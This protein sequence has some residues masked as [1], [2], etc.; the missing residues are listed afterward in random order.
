MDLSEMRKG[1]TYAQRGRSVFMRRMRIYGPVFGKR[2]L[3]LAHRRE[4]VEQAMGTFRKLWP[5]V[6]VG[7]Y[8]GSIKEKDAFVVCGS[9]QSVSQ[10]LEDFDPNEF[11]Y[12][13][14]DECHHGTADTYRKVMS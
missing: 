4:L 7:E 5:E 6:T 14:I 3:F 2:T 1:R 12:L 11:G 10:N 9:I 8:E 13:I